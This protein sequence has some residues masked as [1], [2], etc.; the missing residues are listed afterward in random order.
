MGFIMGM[1][2]GNLASMLPGK[3]LLEDAILGFKMFKRGKLA[4]IPHR[5]KGTRHVQQIMKKIQAKKLH[6]EQTK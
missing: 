2:A 3:A 6:Q 5:A 4:L 1:K